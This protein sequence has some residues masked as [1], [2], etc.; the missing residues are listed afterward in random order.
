MGHWVGLYHTFQGGCFG[1]G[2][3]VDDT[4]PEAIASAGCPEGRDTCIG[5]GV[6]P[7][8]NFMDYSDDEYVSHI[9]LGEK[10]PVLSDPP[11][12]VICSCLTEF[13]PGQITRLQDQ[14]RTFRG[15]NV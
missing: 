9:R 5:G 6:D 10:T 1:D 2:D 13:T 11:V 14:V 3:L 4:P 12:R 7:I 15:V 8:H